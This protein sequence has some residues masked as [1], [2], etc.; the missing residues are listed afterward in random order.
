MEEISHLFQLIPRLLHAGREKLEQVGNLLHIG[1]DVR[2]QRGVEL[3]KRLKK[4]ADPS[5]RCV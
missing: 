4:R 2:L 3:W 1:L 5:R